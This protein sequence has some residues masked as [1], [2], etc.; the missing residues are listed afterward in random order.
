[1]FNTIT[2]NEIENGFINS[3]LVEFENRVIDGKITEE[4][5]KQI[6]RDWNDMVDSMRD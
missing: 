6:D 2:K 5:Q 1:M 4:E 3:E